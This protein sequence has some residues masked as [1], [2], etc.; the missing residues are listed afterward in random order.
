MLLLMLEHFSII[1]NL[2]KIKQVIS[3]KKKL[4]SY[5]LLLEGFLVFKYS[6]YHNEIYSIVNQIKKHNYILFWYTLRY[7]KNKIPNF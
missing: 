4:I 5:M 1:L 7:I 6:I 2:I 3:I